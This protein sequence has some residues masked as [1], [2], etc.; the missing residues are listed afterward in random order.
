MVQRTYSSASLILGL[1][2]VG[3][4]LPVWAYIVWAYIFVP[5][6][7]GAFHDQWGLFILFR[8]TLLGSP[9]AGIGAVIL[10]RRALRAEATSSGMAVAICGIIL[11]GLGLLLHLVTCV[12]ISQIGLAKVLRF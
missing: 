7:Q 3:L 2:S 10:G 4:T 12:V 8:L 11:G 9:I 1:L 5:A 6:P